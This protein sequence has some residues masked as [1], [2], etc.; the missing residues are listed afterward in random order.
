VWVQHLLN[1]NGA[2]NGAGPL[3]VTGEIGDADTAI[4]RHF[5]TERVGLSQP[6]GRVDPEGRT[7]R[8]LSAVK[9]FDDLG[10]ELRVALGSS[11]VSHV[12]GP[13]DVQ[14]FI[15][16]Y[17]RQFE[18]LA[19]AA[20][21]GLAR[22]L[23]F[24]DADPEVPDVRHRAYLLATVKHECAGRWLPIEEYKKGGKREYARPVSVTDAAG[25]VFTHAYYGRGYVQLTWQ[26]NYRK[27]GNELGMG[28]RLMLE[29]KLALDP[30]TSYRI[31]SH[32]MRVGSFTS[33]KLSDFIEGSRCDYANARRIVNGT[34]RQQ[35][36]AGHAMRLELLLRLSARHRSELSS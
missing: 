27:L 25:N 10:E 1:L 14:R 31:L 30:Q 35:E 20:R 15:R 22:L 3:E 9:M 12:L 16:L 36:I 21:G 13:I 28:D 8:V 18:D 6:D 34:D 23:E 4:I 32:G 17:E 5:Q 26:E 33:K 7:L 19:P 11:G 29:P 24:I 2:A